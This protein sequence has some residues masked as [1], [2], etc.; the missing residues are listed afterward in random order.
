[1]SAIHIGPRTIINPLIKD[2]ATFLETSAETN[3]RRTLIQVELAPAGGNDLH[4][5][6]TFDETFT[7]IKGTL[8]IQTGK[9][10]H[11]LL[12]GESITANAGQLHRFFNPSKEEAIVFNVSLNP[13]SVGFENTLQVVYGLA[14]DG[15][16]TSKCVPKNPYHLGLITLWSDTNMPGWMSKLEPV[17]RWFARQ[18]IREGIDR[19]LLARYC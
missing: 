8:G 9:E 18:A 3:G 14:S 13:G 10:I 7:V 1:M 11:Y 17:L 12:P 19:E 6:K 16:T 2:K 5:H 4:Y 15:L